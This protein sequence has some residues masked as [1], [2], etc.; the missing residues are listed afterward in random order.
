MES[1]HDHPAKLADARLVSCG[2]ESTKSRPY[3]CE[4]DRSIVQKLGISAGALMSAIT[5]FKARSC[6]STPC[7][8][9][10]LFDAPDECMGR[11]K[12]PYIHGEGVQGRER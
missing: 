10:Y 3:L 12:Q 6:H 11:G 1:G 2:K 7:L 8:A 9:E 5:S 4:R